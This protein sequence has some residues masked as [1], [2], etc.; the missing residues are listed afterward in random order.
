MEILKRI[1][2]QPIK[3]RGPRQRSPTTKQLVMKMFESENMMT[4][5]E[6]VDELA[7]IKVPVSQPTIK[8]IVKLINY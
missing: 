3:K 5:K 7:K 2:K 4:E 8:R 1:E 6:I